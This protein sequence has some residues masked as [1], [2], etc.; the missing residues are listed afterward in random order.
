MV[1][2]YPSIIC[3]LFMYSAN[4]GTML[5]SEFNLVEVFINLLTSSCTWTLLCTHLIGQMVHSIF[6]L[7]Q[8][9]LFNLL[10]KHLRNENSKDFPLFKNHLDLS[11]ALVPDGPTTTGLT[12]AAATNSLLDQV[13]L[14][15]IN[16]D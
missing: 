2:L 5:R 8:L 16:F 4:T 7:M 10:P 15:D 13:Q 9:V 1:L 12:R 3:I 6:A 11:L 14:M